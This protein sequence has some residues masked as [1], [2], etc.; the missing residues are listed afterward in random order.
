ME[1]SGWTYG[2]LPHWND[3]L[4]FVTFRLADSLPIDSLEEM[5]QFDDEWLKK[6]GKD[7]SEEVETQYKR[8]R[9]F[10]ENKLLDKALGNCIL[11]RYDVRKIVVDALMYFNN[12]HY[13][14][15][16]FV[17]MPNHVHMLIEVFEHYRIQDIMHSLKSFTANEINKMLGM[18]GA[19]WER[20]YYDRYIRNSRHYHSV[21]N[22]IEDNPRH[23]HR[24]EFA[25]YLN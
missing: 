24:G 22:Y 2:D 18:T 16:A 23:C 19:V 12:K 11:K 25:L 6:N 20:E 3:H 1:K 5:K 21:V 14:L 8:E 9:K 15:H 17:I 10:F 7:W 13:L 4:L